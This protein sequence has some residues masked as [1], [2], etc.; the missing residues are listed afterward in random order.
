MGVW[1]STAWMQEVEQRRSNCRGVKAVFLAALQRLPERHHMD[2]VA[3]AQHHG[4]VVTLMLTQ[5]I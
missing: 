5:T 1:Q 4:W 2:V 3:G